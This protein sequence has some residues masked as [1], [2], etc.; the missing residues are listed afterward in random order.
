GRG[1]NTRGRG[2]TLATKTAAARAPADGRV[3][4]IV[5]STEFPANPRSKVAEELGALLAKGGR[6][7]VLEDSACLTMMALR[8]FRSHAEAEPRLAEW[9]VQEKPLSQMPG[10]RAILGLDQLRAQRAPPPPPLVA[11]APPPPPPP[12]AAPPG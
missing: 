4:V 5:R 7:A 11:P 8:E 3:P 2:G 10:L 12:A 6:R 1:A 9:L